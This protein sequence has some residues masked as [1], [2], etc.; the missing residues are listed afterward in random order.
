MDFYVFVL[1]VLLI[2]GAAGAV[3][4]L[5]PRRSVDDGDRGNHADDFTEGMALVDENQELTKQ[6]SRMEGRIRVLER[7]T[8]DSAGRIASEIENLR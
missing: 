7:I 4:A 6:V 1:L 5:I 8:T 3:K 2:T